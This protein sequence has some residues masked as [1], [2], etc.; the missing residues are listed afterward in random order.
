[1]KLVLRNDV[2]N[3]SSFPKPSRDVGFA[4]PRREWNNQDRVA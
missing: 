3:G 1:M 4:T 2:S